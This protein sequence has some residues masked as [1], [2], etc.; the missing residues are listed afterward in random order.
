MEGWQQR[1]L[2]RRSG[3]TLRR[4]QPRGLVTLAQM[5]KDRVTW[6]VVVGVA[7]AS[8]LLSLQ[9]GRLLVRIPVSGEFTKRSILSISTKGALSQ[10][11]AAPLNAN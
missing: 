7:L 4:E 9:S 2:L 11:A 8:P 3:D 6:V 5:F 1:R 10:A